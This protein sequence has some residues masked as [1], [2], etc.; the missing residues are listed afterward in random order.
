MDF[1]SWLPIIIFIYAA[2]TIFGTNQKKPQ[3]RRPPYN[4]PQNGPQNSRPTSSQQETKQSRPQWREMFEELEREL[5]PK[6]VQ[7]DTSSRTSTTKRY[8]TSSQRYDSEGTSGTEGYGTEGRPSEDYLS[9]E[10]S[11][12]VEGT[13][14][15]EGSTSREGA[16][17]NEGTSGRE[18]NLGVAGAKKPQLELVGKQISNVGYPQQQAGFAFPS[19]A[20]N[21]LIQG[22]IWAEVLGK[23]RAHSKLAYKRRA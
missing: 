10:G 22:V 1:F 13:S 12:G 20:V 7:T 18:G 23:P 6:E 3:N 19:Q 8:P 15:N 4:R 21:P 2:S 11:W 14:G 9:A 5:F 16:L 17:G